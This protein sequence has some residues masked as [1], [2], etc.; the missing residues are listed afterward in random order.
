MDTPE[1]SESKSSTPAATMPQSPKDDPL[2]AGAPKG[3]SKEP[4]QLQKLSYLLDQSNI[5]SKII[6]ESQ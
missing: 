1:L 3:E 4:Q 6:G 2:Q 5:Y